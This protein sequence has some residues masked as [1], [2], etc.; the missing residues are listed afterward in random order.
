MKRKGNPNGLLKAINA[1]P[2][3]SFRTKQKAKASVIRKYG[4]RRGRRAPRQGQGFEGF[5]EAS[6]AGAKLLST[7]IHQGVEGYHVING[8]RKMW[9][10]AEK[11]LNENS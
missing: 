2:Y 10:A 4:I 6:L 9:K 5:K 8:I 1:N 7:P 3:M 11:W